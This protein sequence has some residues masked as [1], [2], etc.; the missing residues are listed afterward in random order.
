M[1]DPQLNTWALPKAILFDNDGVLVHSEP[2]HWRAWRE[3][4][5]QKLG[6]PYDEAIIRSMVG[7]TAPQILERILDRYKP[8]WREEP[9]NFNLEAL[10]KSKNQI[11]GKRAR[12]ELVSYPGVV[13]GLRLL[14]ELGIGVAVVSNAKRTELDLAL[15]TTGL[16]DWVGPRFSRDDVARPKPDPQMFERAC[17]ELGVTPQETWAIDDSPTGLTGALLAGCNTF[18][19]TNN[20]ERKDLEAPIPGRPDLRPLW[21]AE[22]MAEFFDAV[23][24]RM[25]VNPMA[26]LGS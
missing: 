24:L 7:K 11:Y 17:A 6:V 2:L 18:S 8:Y 21:I 26:S 12:L 9:E 10:A 23:R 20:F 5:E 1:I 16:M 4:C 22:S 25:G 3:L 14:R 19:V 15:S 13:A